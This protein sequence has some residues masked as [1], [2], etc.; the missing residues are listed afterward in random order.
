MCML[1]LLAAALGSAATSPRVFTYSKDVALILYS[2]CASCHHDGEVA[3]FPLTSYDDARKHSAQ[4]ATVV[5]RRIM[6]PWQPLPGYNHLQNERRLSPAE[7]TAIE[8]W[9]ASA[10]PR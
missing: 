6:P 5:R 3:P 8:R 1:L 7:I 2:K 10:A 9:A 4:I